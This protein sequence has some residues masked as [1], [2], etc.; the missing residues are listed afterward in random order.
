MSFW[1]NKTIIKDNVEYYQ[2]YIACPICSWGARPSVP[3]YW[4][5]DNCGGNMYIGDNGYYYCEKCGYTAPIIEWGYICADC[6]K[7]GHENVVIHDNLEHVGEALAVTG[8]VASTGAGLKWL[9]RVTNALI[10]Q[11]EE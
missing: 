4:H 10:Q 8:M 2:L 6:Q 11:C 5:H 3:A 9:A 7:C 1:E